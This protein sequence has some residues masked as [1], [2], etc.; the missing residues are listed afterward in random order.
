MQGRSVFVHD[1]VL[2]LIAPH[3]CVLFAI[4]VFDPYVTVMWCTVRIHRA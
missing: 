1:V 2:G 4:E 3:Y